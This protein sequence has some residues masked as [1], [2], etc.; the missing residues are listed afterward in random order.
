MSSRN[1]AGE[2]SVRLEGT[3]F[4][5]YRFILRQR[6][7]V[8]VSD[9]QRGLGLSSP[10]VS[11][12][13]IRK[14]MRFGLIREEAEGYVVEKVVL[15]NV[16][17]IRRMSIPVQSAYVAFFSATLIVMLAFLR[18]AGSTS[19]YFFAV[20]VNLAAI[21]ISLYESIKTMRQL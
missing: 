20:A 4:R 21:G 6:K 11:Q 2:G 1:D 8:G 19:L 9:V 12:Y 5:V 10:S 18:P 3:T 7:P 16:I 17:R 14:L 13:H 15:D